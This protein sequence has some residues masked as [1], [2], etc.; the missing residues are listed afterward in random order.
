M[1]KKQFKIKSQVQLKSSEKKKFATEV[2]SIFPRLSASEISEITSNKVDIMKMKILTFT[3][4]CVDVYIVDKT[5]L[6]FEIP[7]LK[8]KLPTI[9][10]CWKYPHIVTTFTTNSVVL[11]KL[12]AGADLFLPG[13]YTDTEEYQSCNFDERD[14]AAV[15][16]I[17]N[18]AA[19]VVGRCLAPKGHFTAPDSCL[20]SGR[21][22]KVFHSVGDYLCKYHPM[23][24]PSMGTPAKV[25]GTIF[26]SIEK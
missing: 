20:V 13:V 11:E 17:T 1:F 7:D 18:A 23:P 9:Y 6:F 10:M 19:C 24:V 2:S 8:C 12:K 3:E 5:P 26:R 14:P 15:N 4:E 22:L 25:S 21:L 16:V